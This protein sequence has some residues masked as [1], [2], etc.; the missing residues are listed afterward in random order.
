MHISLVH[1]TVLHSIPCDVDCSWTW[2]KMN[3]I[4][5]LDVGWKQNIKAHCSAE[6]GMTSWRDLWALRSI[7]E[8]VKFLDAECWAEANVNTSNREK[9]SN[10]WCRRAQSATL[11]T[12]LLKASTQLA[13]GKKGK[14]EHFNVKVEQRLAQIH[15]QQIL[16]NV[17]S[18][19]IWT[20]SSQKQPC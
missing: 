8:K 2:L 15:A 18:N 14:R 4:D 5:E 20:Q 7:T 1:S 3:K 9:G 17:C 19:A 13:N 10:V 12:F 11:S 6:R 16:A